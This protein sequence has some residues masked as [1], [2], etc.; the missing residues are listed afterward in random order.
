MILDLDLFDK[1]WHPLLKSLSEQGFTIEAGGD[2]TKNGRVIGS[3]L[4][5]VSRNGKLLRLL[6]QEDSNLNAVKEVLKEQEISVVTIK[7]ETP[8]IEIIKLF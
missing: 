2:V 7:L 3:Y 1:S 5:E 8:A 4:A 6:D